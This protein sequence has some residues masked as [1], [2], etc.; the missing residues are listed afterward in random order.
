MIVSD[1]I[2]TER[3]KTMTHRIIC[4][5][6][7]KITNSLKTANDL[8]DNNDLCEDCRKEIDLDNVYD[9]REELRNEEDTDEG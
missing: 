6:C 4:P 2:Y 5:L 1:T 9:N 8:L 7:G 3:E